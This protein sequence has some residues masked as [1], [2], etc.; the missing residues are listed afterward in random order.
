MFKDWKTLPHEEKVRILRRGTKKERSAKIHE[1]YNAT[2]DA[3]KG[4]RLTE[5]IAIKLPMCTYLI[6]SAEDVIEH[7]KSEAKKVRK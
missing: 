7:C 4:D 1:R 6:N 3:V 5:Y 2:I